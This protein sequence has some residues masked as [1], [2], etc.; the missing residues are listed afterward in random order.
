MAGRDCLADAATARVGRAW[1]AVERSGGGTV[2]NLPDAVGLLQDQKFLPQALIGDGYTLEREAL[3]EAIGTRLDQL[4][5]WSDLL[6]VCKATA[7]LASMVSTGREWHARRFGEVCMM[8]L[9]SG[10]K[11]TGSRFCKYRGRF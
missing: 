3:A 1:P 2:M 8:H 11:P 4:T 6:T 7:S 10:V 9:N 5:G